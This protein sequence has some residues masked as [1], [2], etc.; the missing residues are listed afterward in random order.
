[1]DT[2]NKRVSDS[3]RELTSLKVIF[4]SL[5]MQDPWV[6]Q[7]LGNQEAVAEYLQ[8][9]TTHYKRTQERAQNLLDYATYAFTVT[10]NASAANKNDSLPSNS[11]RGMASNMV[12]IVEKQLNVLAMHA[13]YKARLDGLRYIYQSLSKTTEKTLKRPSLLMQWLC[14]IVTY[15]PTAGADTEGADLAALHAR[16]HPLRGKALA[17]LALLLRHSKPQQ[18][19]YTQTEGGSASSA[20]ELNTTLAVVFT[21]FQLPA[22]WTNTTTTAPTIGSGNSSALIGSVLLHQCVEVME[23]LGDADSTYLAALGS[24]GFDAL[25]QLMAQVHLMNGILSDA[26]LPKVHVDLAKALAMAAETQVELYKN[27]QKLPPAATPASIGNGPE[28]KVNG[29]GSASLLS[30]AAY[31]Q[32][33]A[34]ASL[35]IQ[36]MSQVHLS[37]EGTARENA[38]SKDFTKA[39]RQ[40]L[41]S[42]AAAIAE[43]V[44]SSSVH[45]DA[46]Q[47]AFHALIS[48]ITLDKRP[49]DA[50]DTVERYPGAEITHALMTTLTEVFIDDVKNSGGANPDAVENNIAAYPMAVRR[51]E[52]RVGLLGSLWDA[53]MSSGGKKYSDASIIGRSSK[54]TDPEYYDRGVTA[55]GVELLRLLQMCLKRGLASYGRTRDGKPDKASGMT[56]NDR[57]EMRTA[58][59]DCRI[60]CISA[61]QDLFSRD[62]AQ[63]WILRN[64]ASYFKLCL[65]ELG[66]PTLLVPGYTAFKNASAMTEVT[67]HNRAANE[68]NANKIVKHIILALRDHEKYTLPAAL[69]IVRAAELLAQQDAAAFFLWWTVADISHVPSLAVVLLSCYG[70]DGCPK[71]SATS[72]KN[73]NEDDDEEEEPVAMQWRAAV[74][75]ALMNLVKYSSESNFVDLRATVGGLVQL[76]VNDLQDIIAI[77]GISS[78]VEAKNVEE[79]ENEVA[80]NKKTLSPADLLQKLNTKMREKRILSRF[81]VTGYEELQRV[82]ESCGAAL[83]AIFTKFTA[84][85]PAK[86]GRDGLYNLLLRADNPAEVCTLSNSLFQNKEEI[87]K[88]RQQQQEAFYKIQKDHTENAVSPSEAYLTDILSSSWHPCE[89][90]FPME[91]LLQTLCSIAGRPPT[92]DNDALQ[93][94]LELDITRAVV[95]ALFQLYFPKPAAADPDKYLLQRW[96]DLMRSVSQAA[97]KASGIEQVNSYNTALLMHSESGAE[98][99]VSNLRAKLK[100]YVSIYGTLYTYA[101][102]VL[103]TIGDCIAIL[104]PGSNKFL[105]E[106]SQFLPSQLSEVKTPTSS[107]AAELL[108][109]ETNANES[110]DRILGLLICQLK[111]VTDA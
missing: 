31:G 104:I 69:D 73:A 110:N 14:A 85:A 90:I 27:S 39:Q 76:L 56:A 41:I 38:E 23:T 16:A 8:S 72:A 52:A 71:A 97:V 51:I 32:F 107:P 30:Y 37:V 33:S 65:Q 9:Y 26:L 106:L 22:L 54:E 91:N 64:D 66:G 28:V 50:E 61:A 103:L 25:C 86:E 17:I 79:N 12:S 5:N 20:D 77:T 35:C 2:R 75:S 10:S 83:I 108:E 81:G 58:C 18:Q 82:M 99:S 70:M 6:V 1:M 102:E 44:R 89:W 47:A 96:V 34:G 3:T 94:S 40:L 68:A 100:K 63:E 87:A 78:H 36:N 42:A 59:A 84:G 53:D 29:A 60:G 98:K 92:F 7:E 19:T 21:I 24:C 93:Q 11:Q 46:F 55:T 45:H 57:T 111:K 49:L 13:E 109:K 105:Q 15:A 62:A 74:L 101:R 67:E 95:I 48:V 88:N 80:Q 43:L 4:A